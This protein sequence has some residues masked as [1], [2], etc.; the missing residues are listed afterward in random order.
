MLPFMYQPA[1][2]DA[3]FV[4]AFV[5]LHVCVAGVV[6][7]QLSVG[8]P[9]DWHEVHTWIGVCH[10]ISDLLITGDDGGALQKIGEFDNM[11]EASAAAGILGHLHKNG[12][13][14]YNVV[15]NQLKNP[16]KKPAKATA[17]SSGGSFYFIYTCRVGV[18]YAITDVDIKAKLA[19]RG[20]A[21]DKQELKDRA[22][23]H[24]RRTWR[25]LSRS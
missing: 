21:A 13:V 5:S 25:I 22:T 11:A 10:G 7:F 17:S 14:E 2:A 24:Q 8:G 20:N 16:S 23:K 15:R 4:L 9:A 18:E 19:L 3:R 6:C 1:G 12:S